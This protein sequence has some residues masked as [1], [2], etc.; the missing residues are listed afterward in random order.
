MTWTIGALA[1]TIENQRVI[2]QLETEP[3]GNHPLPPLDV[4]IAELLD[5]AALQT[6]D[7]VVVRTVIEFKHGVT[8]LK[9]VASHQASGLELGEHPVHGRQTEFFAGILQ[10]SKNRLGGQMHATLM[11]QHVKNL[12]ARQRHF[13][14][15]LFEFFGSHAELSRDCV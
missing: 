14:T 12:H 15:R 6:Q 7:M 8:T 13:Q 11:L 2:R 4:L 5:M 1:M 9:M 10:R 3:L